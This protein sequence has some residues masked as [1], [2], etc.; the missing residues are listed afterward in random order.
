MKNSLYILAV[1]F[2]FNCGSNEECCQHKT[3]G[4]SNIEHNINLNEGEKWEVNSEMKP[5]LIKGEKLLNE[6]VKS[7]DSDYKKLANN[8]MEQNSNLINACSMKG[9]SHD[10]LHKWLYPHME[11]IKKLKTI[12]NEKKANQIIEDLNSSFKIYNTYFI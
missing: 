10:E 5:F 3:E 4:N 1:V 6:Y 2:L 11:L 8:L 9:E 12:E 7:E